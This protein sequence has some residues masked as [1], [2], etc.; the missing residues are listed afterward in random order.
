V[1]LTPIT[2]CT[3]S[4]AGCVDSQLFVIRFDWPSPG[5]PC[6]SYHFVMCNGQYCRH[7]MKVQYS[8]QS[9][10]ELRS[11]FHGTVGTRL[12][13]PQE[14][15]WKVLANGVTFSNQHAVLGRSTLKDCIVK[16]NTFRN[17]LSI[18]TKQCT[19]GYYN[20]K[21]RFSNFNKDKI[22]RDRSNTRKRQQKSI[23]FWI[24]KVF[25]K[26]EALLL[27]LSR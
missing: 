24:G 3:P 8:F 26:S 17:G 13:C 22:R 19:D 10:D 12:R 21:K 6:A 25:H 15:L 2:L 5:L 23:F 4:H 1:W 7:V 27:Q 11:S 9:L 14:I 16:E 18:N 20:D